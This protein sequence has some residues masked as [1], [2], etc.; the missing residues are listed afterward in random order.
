M[1]A[2]VLGVHVT[3]SVVLAFVLEYWLKGMVC[4]VLVM[5]GTKESKGERGTKQEILM[6]CGGLDVDAS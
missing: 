2:R 5:A 6:S 1:R 3:Y 4:L